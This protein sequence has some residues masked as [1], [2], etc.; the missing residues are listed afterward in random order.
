[1]TTIRHLEQ[2][3]KASEFSVTVRRRNPPDDGLEDGVDAEARLRGRAQNG[4][5]L[6]VEEVLQ[7]ESILRISFGRNFRTKPNWVKITFAILKNLHL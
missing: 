7:L 3:P 2:E 4:L 6:N 1:M 5:R